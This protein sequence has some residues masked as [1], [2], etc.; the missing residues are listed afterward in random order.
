LHENMRTA[1]WYLQKEEKRHIS[2]ISSIISSIFIWSQSIY[3]LG[4]Y[5]QALRSLSSQTTN[6]FQCGSKSWP[7]PRFLRLGPTLKFRNISV[8]NT[9]VAMTSLEQHGDSCSYFAVQQVEWNHLFATQLMQ[10]STRN[11]LLNPEGKR[12]NTACLCQWNSYQ[13]NL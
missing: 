13:Y 8:L 3:W 2:S 6:A 9:G 7:P 1:F 10:V 4:F 12:E 5:L 11:L